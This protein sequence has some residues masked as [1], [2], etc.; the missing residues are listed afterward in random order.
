MM[1]N[2]QGPIDVLALAVNGETDPGL[3]D[4]Q[5]RR[6]LTGLDFLAVEIAQVLGDGGG[7]RPGL[8]LGLN[9]LIV[10]T[11]RVVI[12]PVDLL[13]LFHIASLRV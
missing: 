4:R 1:S 3:Q 2:G 8:A 11:R 9:Q 12:L 13:V 5:F 6:V 10:E 7:R